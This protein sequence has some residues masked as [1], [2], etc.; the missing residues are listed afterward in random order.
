MPVSRYDKKYLLERLGFSIADR[1]LVRNMESMGLSVEETNEKEMAV[2]FP[3]NRPD[4]IG[5]VGMARAL[6]HFMRRTRKFD[7]RLKAP[8]ST[9][10]IN[11]GRHAAGVRPFI[12]ALIAREMRLSEV[13]LRDIINMTEKLSDTFGRHRSKIALG[14]HDL[15]NAK[16]P[17]FYD[18]YEDEYYVPL[19][20]S[21]QMKYSEV[22]AMEE[23]GVQ[24]GRLAGGHGRYVALKDTLG[25]M[26]LIPVL[27]SDRTR[28]SASTQEM[29]VDITG[30]SRE[31]V[32]KVADL[33]AADF[34][35]MGFEV[36]QVSVRYGRKDEVTPAMQSSTIEMQLEQVQR[37]IGVKIGFNNAILLSNKMGY[38]ASLV[39]KRIRFKSPA[40]R[41]DIINDQDIVEDIAV[42]YGYDYIQLADIVSSQQGELEQATKRHEQ[43]G[44]ALVGLGFDE[45]MGSY[46]TNPETN[47]A[48]M[49]IREGGAITIQ[50]PKSSSATMLRTW[51]LPSLL[52]DAG[53]SMHDRMPIKLFELDMAFALEGGRPVEEQHLAAIA[54][55]PQANFNYIKA[56]LEG[57]S[58]KTGIGTDVRACK[59][60]SFIEGRCAEISVGGKPIGTMGEVHPEV[61]S[62][63]GIEEAT[64]ALE[65]NL[66]PLERKEAKPR[67]R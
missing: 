27:N 14:L 28:V 60:S 3:A 31:V 33:L 26:S 44:A 51:L 49:R 59:H 15:R 25:T 61:L 29:L 12:A 9:D 56:V 11:V 53:A 24:Y 34:S 42:A 17:F 57:I 43:L 65:L 67:E 63:F 36:G 55:Y 16:A 23:K 48:A 22:V 19:G 21:K 46:L 50:N 1:E 54:C 62:N 66:S 37:E 39:G 32:G 41:L 7:Y 47:F 38:M 6:R 58:K 4:L 30:T 64:L 52:K 20:R 13:Q 40:Y 10:V 2:E 8:G 45:E 5:T 35:D 18:A